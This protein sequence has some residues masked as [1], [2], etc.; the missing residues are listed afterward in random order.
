MKHRVVIPAVHAHQREGL[1]LAATRSDLAGGT[2]LVLEVGEGSA[3]LELAAPK[4]FFVFSYGDAQWRSASEEEGRAFVDEVADWLGLEPT[5]VAAD[6][7]ADTSVNCSWVKLGGGPDPFGTTWDGFKLFFDAGERDAEV[8]FRVAD[9]GRRAQLLEKWSEYRL[10]LVELLERALA[11]PPFRTWARRR[12]PP[13]DAGGGLVIGD[14]D[15]YELVLPDGWVATWQ[16]EGHWRFADPDDEMVIELSHLRL[17]PLP[18]DAP[19]VMERLRVIIEDSKHRDSAS[20]IET[21][22]RDGMTVAWSEYTFMSND[23]LRPEAAPRPARGRWLIAAN[24]WVQV[25][26]TGCWWE[27]DIPIA[28][29][30]WEGLIASIDIARR[31]VTRDQPSGDA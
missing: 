12:R 5:D 22:E 11:P 7:S 19:G 4:G 3:I 30:A 9:D 21:F 26:V 23:T 13:R 17:P 8:F 29:A 2:H 31:V 18:E 28:V 6:D 15:A 25:L 1:E 10:P 20:A 27:D 24:D 16:P 14:D